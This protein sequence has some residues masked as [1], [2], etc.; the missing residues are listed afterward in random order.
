MKYKGIC[1]GRRLDVT[2]KSKI[3]SIDHGGFGNNRGVIIIGRSVNLIIAG[4]SVSGSEFSTREDLPNDVE[5][6]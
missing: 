4:E 3:K 6:L 1:G 5:V 2:G